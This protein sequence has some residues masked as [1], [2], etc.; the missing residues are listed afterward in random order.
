M[1]IKINNQSYK[2]KKAVNTLLEALI[3]IKENI[4]P[5][6]NFD[7]GCKSGVCGACSVR[8]NGKEQLACSFEPKDGDVVEPI[9][10][11]PILRDLIVDKSYQESLLKGV[12]V[13][14]NNY[15]NVILNTKD[16][17]LLEFIK[18]KHD[19]ER[20]EKGIEKQLVINGDCTLCGECT[21]V[22]PQNIDPKNDI[23]KL[24]NQSAQ[25]GY[26]DPNFAN[27]GFSGGFGF[28]PNGGF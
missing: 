8:V 23:I 13:G 6:L 17:A 25:H 27:M 18:P 26:M 11:S 22:C 5:E 28:D 14:I 21:L 12:K 2:I 16:E 15:Q 10:Y 4:K 3:Y 24:R 19:K 1:Q 20:S 9:K 7:Y